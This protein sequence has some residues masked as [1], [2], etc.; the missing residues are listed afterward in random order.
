ML[1]EK[2][3]LGRFN[4]LW[5]MDGVGK[6]DWRR[7]FVDIFSAED[8]GLPQSDERLVTRVVCVID[9]RRNRKLQAFHHWLKHSRT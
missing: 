3:S 1:M 7:G 2:R 4:N 6:S 9:Q 8:E 5:T